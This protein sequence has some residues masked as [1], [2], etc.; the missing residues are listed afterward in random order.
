[1]LI[2]VLIELKKAKEWCWERFLLCCIYVWKEEVSS[3]Y[4]LSCEVILHFITIKEDT[5]FVHQ[6]ADLK[7]PC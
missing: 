4:E 3:Q 5:D 1:M 6:L 7:S 2:F